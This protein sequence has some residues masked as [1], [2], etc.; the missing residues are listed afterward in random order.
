MA[1]CGLMESDLPW[2]PQIDT[3]KGADPA[4]IP[5]KF[6]SRCK[7][8]DSLVATPLPIGLN[9]ILTSEP[10]VRFIPIPRNLRQRALRI[11]IVALKSQQVD[12]YKDDE[13][14]DAL[15]KWL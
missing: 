6:R 1:L 15:T 5:I 9:T 4:V 7:V 12:S 2:T 14:L 10:L 13:E 11:I 3:T 8:S